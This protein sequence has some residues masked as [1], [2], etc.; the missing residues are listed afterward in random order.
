[1]RGGSSNEIGEGIRDAVEPVDPTSGSFDAVA[2]FEAAVRDANVP[3]Q[4]R[5]EY[6][7]TDHLHPNDAGYKAMA[8][9]VDLSIFTQKPAVKR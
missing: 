6:N 2:D 4:F 1:M 7:N 9:S 5:A 3:T 8:D